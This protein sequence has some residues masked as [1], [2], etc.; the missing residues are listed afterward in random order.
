MATGTAKVVAQNKQEV[1]KNKDKKELIRQEVSSAVSTTS[2]SGGSGGSGHT[3]TLGPAQFRSPAKQKTNNMASP[4]KIKNVGYDYKPFQMK[5]SGTKYNNSPIEKNYGSPAQR[6]F[7]FTGGVGSNEMEGGVGSAFDYA[8]PA[9]GWFSNIANKVGGFAKK[10]A[11]T[12]G[13]MFG[14]NKGG[15]EEQQAV[16]PGAEGVEG[17]EG[18]GGGEVPMHGPE[19][20][21]GGGRG[22]MANMMMNRSGNR[23]WGGIGRA[24]GGMM[25]DVRLK[26]KIQK[27]GIS[28]S[29]IP[30][31]EFNYIG[32]TSRYSGAMAQDL[33][34]MGIDAVS[35][36][37]SG[38]YQ[39]NY[40][41]I[42]VDMHQIN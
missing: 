22:K 35:V 20:H 32:D 8:S 18:G 31:Y 3:H 36:H 11:G 19:S 42:D 2:D 34:D 12:V 25:S 5:A 38:Y 40:N 27:P 16:E 37:E 21:S 6:G 17:V 10:A 14:V 9:K 4:N 29:G 13:G 28:P 26:E 1:D 30:I 39:V 15:G 23:K 41:N 24:V 7:D 33:L